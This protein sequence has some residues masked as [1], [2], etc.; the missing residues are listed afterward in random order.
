MN[1]HQSLSAQMIKIR[2]VLVNDNA[3]PSGTTEEYESIHTHHFVTLI[4]R[5]NA[6]EANVSKSSR[7]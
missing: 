7:K 4:T 1:V 5:M 3:N 2:I 6:Y